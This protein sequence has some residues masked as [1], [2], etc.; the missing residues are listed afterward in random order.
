M[1][2]DRKRAANNSMKSETMSVTFTFSIAFA[3]FQIA[4]IVIKTDNVWK[5]ITCDG[6]CKKSFHT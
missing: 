2:N 3:P 5:K 6:S 4:A 1:T